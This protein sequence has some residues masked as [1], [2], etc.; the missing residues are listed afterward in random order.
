LKT[1]DVIAARQKRD[2][3]LARFSASV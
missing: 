1:A 3:V 2:H